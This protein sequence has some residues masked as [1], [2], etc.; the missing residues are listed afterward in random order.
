MLR[1]RRCE[2]RYRKTSRPA[3]AA[4]CAMRRVGHTTLKS[5]SLATYAASAFPPYL[6]GVYC[7]TTCRTEASLNGA[8]PREPLAVAAHLNAS[9]AS[10]SALELVFSGGTMPHGRM[11]RIP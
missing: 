3:A 5:A 2:N 11:P 10:S 4:E 8:P 6:A 1:R 7:S 9:A